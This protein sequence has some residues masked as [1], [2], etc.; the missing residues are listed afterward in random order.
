MTGPRFC[1]TSDSRRVGEEYR[2]DNFRSPRSRRLQ[3]G[4]I[5]RRIFPRVIEQNAPERLNGLFD[6]L[7][8]AA[9]LRAA[10]GIS[11]LDETLD[12]MFIEVGS[13][14]DHRGLQT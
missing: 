2:Y 5:I 10:Q 6:E 1:E 4:R 9:S 8:Q 12:E 11:S 13:E 3:D 14:L 7:V